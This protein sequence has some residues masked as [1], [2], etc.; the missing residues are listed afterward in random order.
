MPFEVMEDLETTLMGPLG[1]LGVRFRLPENNEEIKYRASAAKEK[2]LSQAWLKKTYAA[3][4]WL[5]KQ[6]ITGISEDYIS[7]NGGEVKF[8]SDRDSEHYKENWKEL[9]ARHLPQY[10]RLLVVAIVDSGHEDKDY[11]KSI[12]DGE[13]DFSSDDL[14]EDPVA[15]KND[16]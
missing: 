10:L 15:E 9:M 4:L 2:T 11:A 12:D 6:M 16:E 13:G 14:G 1:P 5:G 8:S 7:V 3:R